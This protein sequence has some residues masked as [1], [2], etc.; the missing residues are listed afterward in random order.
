MKTSPIA[1]VKIFQTNRWKC[2][3]PELLRECGNGHSQERPFFLSVPL[4]KTGAHELAG[5]P[6]F[7]LG[8]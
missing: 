8:S 4:D 5:L 3:S 2:G 7:G 6:S 1:I